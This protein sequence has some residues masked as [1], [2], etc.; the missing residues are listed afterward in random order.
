[1]SRLHLYMILPVCIALFGCSPQDDQPAE[2]VRPVLS[3]EVASGQAS[4]PQ[5]VGAVAPRLSVEQSFRVGGT[6]AARHVEAGTQVTAGT[7]VATLDATTAKLSVQNA[8]ASLGS[9]E[10]QYANAADAES[11][12]RTLNQSEVVA[13][14]NLE[15]AEQQTAGAHASLVQAQARLKQ[16]EEQL[17]YATL[18]APFDGIVTAVGAEPGA[19]VG[20][21]QMVVTIADANARDV[22]IDVP[23]AI[24]SSV[25]IGTPFMISPQLAPQIEVEGRV[26]EIAPQAEQLTR[27]WRIRI[28]IDAMSEQF[29][30]GTTAIASPVIAAEDTVQI[31]ASAIQRDGDAA[32]VWVIDEKE[33]TV[34][35]RPVALGTPGTVSGNGLVSITSGL[36]SGERIVVAGVNSLTDG[37]RIKLEELAN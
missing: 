4:A 16:A 6:L 24:S 23:E 3:H 12:L 35:L 34:H 21:G 8:R 5:F 7:V 30:L 13:L 27:S 32:G 14:S 2:I 22:V 20:A 26:R 33:A 19:V 36:V 25:S 17:S 11:R 31:P 37:Q 15:Q 28:S 10:A 1:M 9:A 29:W 18:T